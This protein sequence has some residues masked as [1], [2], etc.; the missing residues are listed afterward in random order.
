[1]RVPVVNR[2]DPLIN[3]AGSMDPRTNLVP[4]LGILGLTL[5][6]RIASM[7]PPRRIAG[8]VLVVSTV[9][10]AIDSR[11]GGLAPG[12]V[13]HAVNRTAVAGLPELRALLDTLAVGHPV[14]LQ[15][16]RQ[17]TLLYLTFTVE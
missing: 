7:R 11:E 9:P 1:V 15:L 4:R 17:G 5:D 14:V 8:G 10:G 12:D 6:Q 3:L 16:E 2:E 13:I